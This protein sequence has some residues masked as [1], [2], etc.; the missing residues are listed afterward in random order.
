MRGH[1]LIG[2]LQ[3]GLQR[4]FL[5]AE[6]LASISEHYILIILKWIRKCVYQRRWKIEFIEIFVQ[7]RT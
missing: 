5:A 1:R 6:N 7:M 2:R 4:D 3:F